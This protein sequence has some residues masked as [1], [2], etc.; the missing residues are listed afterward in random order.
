MEATGRRRK[1]NGYWEYQYLIPATGNKMWFL[2]ES[3]PLRKFDDT[4]SGKQ[5]NHSHQQADVIA[6]A[7]PI[8]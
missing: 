6:T 4:R 5:N 7:D 1:G 3:K 2:E 8:R